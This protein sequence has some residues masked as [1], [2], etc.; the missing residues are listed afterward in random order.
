LLLTRIFLLVQ[1]IV[2]FSFPHIQITNQYPRKFSKGEGWEVLLERDVIPVRD[3][4]PAIPTPLA[5]VIDRALD[6][7]NGN[8]PLAFGS[9]I[10]F[11][12]ALQD[13]MRST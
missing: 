4:N 9:A 5:A 3:R 7:G 2:R 1:H 13:A 11:Q 10:E 12:R 8:Q 6:E